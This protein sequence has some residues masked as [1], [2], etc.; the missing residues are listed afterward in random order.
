MSHPC[1][2]D[3]GKSRSRDMFRG[4]ATSLICSQPSVG[5]GDGEAEGG[6][7]FSARLSRSGCRG[8][9]WLRKHQDPELWGVRTVIF[10]ARRLVPFRSEQTT[11]VLFMTSSVMTA[12]PAFL[13]RVSTEAEVGVTWPRVREC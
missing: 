5:S 3:S 9:V 6:R 10:M 1:A 13:T 8:G 11:S 12:S 4:R 2:W 7:G